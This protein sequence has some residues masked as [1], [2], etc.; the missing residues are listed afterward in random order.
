MMALL[1]PHPLPEQ[2]RTRQGRALT[3]GR[4][5]WECCRGWYPGKGLPRNP[6]QRDKSMRS[7]PSEVLPVMREQ[8]P[9]HG[10]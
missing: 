4:E 5:V 7:L 2:S 6:F 10:A 9:G 8:S 1:G 3:W